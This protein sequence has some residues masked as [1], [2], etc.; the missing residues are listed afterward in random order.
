MILLKKD[1]LRFPKSGRKRK[2]KR[3]N[4]FPA[5][6]GAFEEAINYTVGSFPNSLTTSDFNSDG[7]DD[8]AVGNNIGVAVLLNNESG[9]FTTAGIFSANTIPYSVVAADFDED[10]TVDIAAVNTSSKSFAL[11]SVHSRIKNEHRKCIQES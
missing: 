5:G 10:G 6:L 1:F 3:F 9:T 4:P 8:I 7:F 11:R 2:T